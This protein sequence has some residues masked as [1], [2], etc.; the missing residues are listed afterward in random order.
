MAVVAV[1]LNGARG[2]GDDSSVSRILSPTRL[3][4]PCRRGA[5]T[6]TA[7]ASQESVLVRRGWAG[8]GGRQC[9]GDDRLV[10]AGRA[11]GRG[12]VTCV[13]AT[14]HT[15]T[16]ARTHT[17]GTATRAHAHRQ[18]GTDFCTSKRHRVYYNTLLEKPTTLLLLLLPLVLL[19]LLLLPM[20]LPPPPHTRTRSLTHTHAV[21]SVRQTLSVIICLVFRF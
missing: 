10:A 9:G 1:V 19:L 3:D 7:A 15:H 6:A 5:H 17:H 16:R 13:N 21:R 18:L 14:P 12:V 20:L 2:G 11:G 4:G 8:G